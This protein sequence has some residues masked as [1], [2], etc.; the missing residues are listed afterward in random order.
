VIFKVHG[1]IFPAVAPQVLISVALS[2]FAAARSDWLTEQW[3]V[4]G[5]NAE[6]VDFKQM[7]TLLAFLIIFKTNWGVLQFWTGLRHTDSLLEFSRMLARISC[8]LFIWEKGN[9]EALVRKLLRFSVAYWFVIIEYLQRSGAHEVS[10][11]AELDLLRSRIHSLLHVDEIRLLYPDDESIVCGSASRNAYANPQLIL[12]IQKQILMQIYKEGGIAPPPILS[13]S[14]SA[15]NGCDR[16][17]WGMEKLDKV[18]FPLPYN[19]IV[20]ILILTFTFLTPF[21]IVTA[22][23]WATPLIMFFVALGFFGLDEAAEV[24]EQPF[25]ND[26]NQVDLRQH[27]LEFASDAELMY[28]SRDA[29]RKIAF[30]PEGDCDFSKLY[31]GDGAVVSPRKSSFPKSAAFHAVLSTP[32]TVY[33]TPSTVATMPSASPPEMEKKPKVVMRGDSLEIDLDKRGMRNGLVRSRTK[34]DGTLDDD[35]EEE[36]AE[37]GDDGGEGG[38]DGFMD[39]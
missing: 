18:L 17:F 35:D 14:L 15:L 36:E 3:S 33:A 5:L 6:E 37:G 23:G 38:E 21:T 22:C 26:P 39:I 2:V 12:C 31:A 29:Q 19:Q 25:G 10:D 32:S 8:T 1:S 28:H 24:L 30:C 9:T 16:A 13:Q 20:K 27:A 34:E 11:K 4:A 7:G